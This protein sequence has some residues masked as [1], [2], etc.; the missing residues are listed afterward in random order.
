MLTNLFLMAWLAISGL[1]PV[2]AAPPKVDVSKIVSV[3]PYETDCLLLLMADEYATHA[4][5]VR[6]S[7]VKISGGSVTIS[8]DSIMSEIT[9]S[10]PEYT[11]S[12][13]DARGITHTIRTPC[14][15]LTQPECFKQHEFAVNLM[16]AA[17]PPKPVEATK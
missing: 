5:I 11:D 1:A 7:G 12:Y 4:F 10:N 6:T 9:V 13:T 3:T 15:G 17:H 8:D 2:E 14:T 16:V